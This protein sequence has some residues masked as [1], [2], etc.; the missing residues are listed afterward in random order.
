MRKHFQLR[1]NG[2]I[3]LSHMVSVVLATACLGCVFRSVAAAHIGKWQ[4]KAAATALLEC[5][6]Q[7]ANHEKTKAATVGAKAQIVHKMARYGHDQRAAEALRTVSQSSEKLRPELKH[8]IRVIMARAYAALG[9]YKKALAL[10][11]RKAMK[12]CHHSV[13]ARRLIAWEMFRVGKRKRGLT[14]LFHK[15]AVCA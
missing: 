6:L 10:A 9:R 1:D 13:T 7:L 2:V 8:S 15:S 3:N 14:R 12:T 11:D 5:A 4:K